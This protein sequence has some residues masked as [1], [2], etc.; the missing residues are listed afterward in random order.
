VD[1]YK[2]NSQTKKDPF[3]LPF[4]DLVLDIV[5]RYE[6]YSFV[7]EFSGYNQVKMTKE[8]K[9]KMLFIFEWGACAYNV[10][11]FQLCNTPTTFQKVVTQTFKEYFNN[12]MQVFFDDFIVYKHKEEHLNRLNKCMTQ[13]RNNSISLNLE[14]CSFCINFKVL[15]GHIV[16]EDGLLVDP[17]KITSSHICLL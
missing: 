16:S 12:F 2:L 11:P 9:E 8:D 14:K 6:I 7:D 4:L 15:L 10:M 17:R 13:C 5:A 3:S 1:Y